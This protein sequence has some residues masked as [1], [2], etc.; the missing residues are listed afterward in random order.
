[1]KSVVETRNYFIKEI[2]KNELM[3]NK[4]KMACT[5]LNYMEHFLSIAFAVTGC[6]SISGFASLLGSSGGVRE[7]KTSVMTA[8]IEKYNSIVE[9]KKRNV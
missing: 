9:K 4:H 2:V 1:M 6:I 8:G 7:L 3:S 5:T